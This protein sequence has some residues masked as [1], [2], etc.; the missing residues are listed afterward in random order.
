MSRGR[1][2]PAAAAGI[3]AAVVSAIVVLTARGTDESGMGTHEVGTIAP[4]AG[5][6]PAAFTSIVL[7]AHHAVEC[8]RTDMR[9]EEPVQP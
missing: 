9:V 3:L 2:L 6:G 8:A 1:A 5:P 4:A 7:G